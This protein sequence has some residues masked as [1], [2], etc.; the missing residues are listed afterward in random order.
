MKAR[1]ND[2][3]GADDAP[4]HCGTGKIRL[5]VEGDLGAGAGL[6]PDTAQTHYLLNVM[7]VE[8]GTPVRLFNGRD[9][10]W[11]ARIIEVKKRSCLFAVDE[12]TRP[13][14]DLAD[15]WLLFAPV[16]KARLD[17]MVQ[18]AVEMGAGRLQPVMTQHTNVARV[19]EERMA[20]NAV[21]AAE[22]CGLVAVPEVAPAT[23]LDRL[24]DSWD[25][26]APGR[27]IIFCD[28]AA[29]P[30][31]ALATLE[32]A[33]PAGP[34]AVLI[35]PEG[36]FSPR[37]RERL[38]AREDTIALSLGPRIMRAD[39]AAIAALGAVQLV[40]GDWRA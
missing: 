29:E 35:G 33:A 32:A 23:S 12:Q 28:E 7:R 25:E 17:F 9:G 20:A 21:E 18:K 16:K 37:E 4:D 15:L 10:E 40:L 27:R 39:T 8:E 1:G 38:L 19:K 5:Y 36:G 34:L 14:Q 22:Q 24:L 6:I 3:D 2:S 30:G 31:G 13:H 26:Q 11:L